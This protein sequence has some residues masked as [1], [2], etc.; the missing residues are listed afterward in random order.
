MPISLHVCPKGSFI[1]SLTLSLWHQLASDAALA[2]V[3]AL[4]RIF[5]ISLMGKT[6]LQEM[7]LKTKMLYLLLQ[8]LDEERRSH[9]DVL[10]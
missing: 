3:A 9:L 5:K 1:Q 10:Y 7:I 6:T 2:T 8:I 4:L